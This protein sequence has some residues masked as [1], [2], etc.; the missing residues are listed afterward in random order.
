MI[1]IFIAWQTLGPVDGY[2]ADLAS[3]VLS[4]KII[5]LCL[6]KYSQENVKDNLIQFSKT[7]YEM[8]VPE[9]HISDNVQN[10]ELS[11]F[12]YRFILKQTYSHKIRP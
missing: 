4:R 3:A 11:S 7:V 6:F 1:K 5:K 8:H 2:V 12:S 9:S 10:T